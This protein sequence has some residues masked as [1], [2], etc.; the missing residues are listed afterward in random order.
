MTVS[1]LRRVLL[2]GVNEVRLKGR[3]LLELDREGRMILK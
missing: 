1:L 2:H 3:E